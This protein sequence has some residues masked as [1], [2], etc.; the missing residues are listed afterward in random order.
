MNVL[1]AIP[2]P[3]SRP[4]S[5]WTLAQGR[6]STW[7]VTLRRNQRKNHCAPGWPEHLISNQ[8]NKKGVGRPCSRWGPKLNDRRA[9][10]RTVAGQLGPARRRTFVQAVANVSF[11]Q[12]P[13][14]TDIRAEPV[15]H[16]GLGSSPIGG[17]TLDVCPG[18]AQVRKKSEAPL[19]CR[20]RSDTAP[21]RLSAKCA[22]MSVL[23]NSSARSRERCSN[24]LRGL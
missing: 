15:V 12:Y 9:P 17:G 13:P 18:V 2:N 1:S 21:Q 4:L 7:I 6:S 22:P 11:Q 14:E 23:L 16:A 19:A 10:I 20:S 5:H 8:N 3:R 24:E